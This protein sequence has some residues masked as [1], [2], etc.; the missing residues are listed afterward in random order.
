MKTALPWVVALL[1]ACGNSE[2]AGPEDPSSFEAAHS[3]ALLTDRT[4]EAQL[5]ESAPS[6]SAQASLLDTIIDCG[7]VIPKVGSEYVLSEV[8]QLEAI[9]N[10]GCN[11]LGGNLRV[12]FTVPLVSSAQRHL[13]SP[14]SIKQITGRILQGSSFGG[15]STQWIHFV[16]LEQ[17]GSIELYRNQGCVYPVLTT[18]G[19]IQME[20]ALDCQFAALRNVSVLTIKKAKSV[21][22]FNALTSVPSLTIEG[23]TVNLT[24]FRS[25]AT[26]QEVKLAS[27]K[28]VSKN[29]TG[30]LKA[31]ALVDELSAERID[32]RS[33]SLPKLVKVTG[34]ATF[35]ASQSV[36]LAIKALTEVGGSLTL[37]EDS[38]FADLFHEGPAALAKVG[39]S[40]DL[41]LGC[42]WLKGYKGLKT[43]G[44]VLSIGG[45]STNI[46]AFANLTRTGGLSLSGLAVDITGFD[47][48][49]TVGGP[50]QIN[51]RASASS[52]ARLNAL[53]F[54][55][56]VQGP[57]DLVLA[58]DAGESFVKLRSVAGAL[59]YD[60][61]RVSRIY[62]ATP[63]LFPALEQVSGA[64]S[65]S[66]LDDGFNAVTSVG[67]TLS[68]LSVPRY[69]GPADLYGFRKVKTVAGDLVIDKEVTTH[70][71]NSS[72]RLLDQLVGFTGRVILK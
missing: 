40:M 8:S 59:R 3:L 38:S 63:A 11:Y 69:L 18:A 49:T 16:G 62:D 58:C 26:A 39:G 28:G 47:K 54:L 64:L 43:V 48:L 72:Q 20:D 44:G 31:L 9:Y 68:I 61:P 50:L 15:G 21:T 25:L 27:G 65:T 55:T 12:A 7:T 14:P 33:F 10:T 71:P 30:S 1:A 22:G 52:V 19:T 5:V 4:E 67:G 34:N 51:I 53:K 17:V 56:E 41:Q 66:N 46:E 35:R 60:R 57:V 37:H 32:F 45:V 6:E 23:D 13:F 2:L 70:G 42:G 29:W 24:G 36:P